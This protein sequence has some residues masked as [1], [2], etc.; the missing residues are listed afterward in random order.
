MEIGSYP[1]IYNLGHR[2]V[3]DIFKSPTLIQEKVD[4]S[5]ISFMKG[6]TGA[7]FVRSKKQ[8]LY[9]EN[10]E[11]MFAKGLEAIFQTAHQLHPMWVYRGEYL[12]KPKHNVLQYDRIPH[13]HIALYDIQTTNGDFISPVEVE[14]VAGTLGF[15]PVPYWNME[16]SPDKDVL[17]E[18]LNHVSFLGG[19]TLEGVV[20]KNYEMWDLMTG[21]TLMGKYV[22]EAFRE[23][24][25]KKKYKTTQKDVVQSLIENYR[26]DARWQ[27]AV[28]HIRDE[29][30]LEDSPT[31]I[32]SLIKEVCVDVHEE[33]K[34]E[35]QEILFKHFWKQI[36][37][38][39]TA[40]LPEWY[41]E[42]LIEKQFANELAE[43]E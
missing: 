22:S 32:G 8:M 40:G 20:I 24:H 10:P 29:G 6:E 2:A 27:K 36:A 38:G 33:C 43:E 16:D 28:Q 41:K 14:L 37:R 23:V 15:E 31:D 12:Q 5:Q 9:F 25:R 35:I 11:K 7:V 21:K 42:T 4:G 34:D 19:A 39:I 13:N 17:D 3:R 1:K 18:L 26:T 30:K